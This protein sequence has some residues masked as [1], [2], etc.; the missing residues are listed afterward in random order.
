MAGGHYNKDFHLYYDKVPGSASKNNNN[1][2][3]NNNGNN[4]DNNKTI[5]A[6]NR[7]PVR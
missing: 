3:N 4:N 2:N 7:S 1:N 6:G 5:I